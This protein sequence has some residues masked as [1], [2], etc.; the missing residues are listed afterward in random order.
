MTVS[1]LFDAFLGMRPALRRYLLLRGARDDEAE[2]VLQDVSVTLSSGKLGPVSEPGAY[3]YRMATNHFLIHRRGAG[4]RVRREEDWVDVHTGDPPEL[5]EKPST[6]TSLIA[7][8]QLAILQAVIDRMPERTRMIFRRF[9]L[10]GETRPS[11]A[12]D[13]GISISAVEKHLA[14]AYEAITAARLLL[15]EDRPLPR[16]LNAEGGNHG[17]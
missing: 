5:D 14:R 6:E 17:A 8:E 3:L 4:R 2:D 12:S 13:L 9:R 1:G 11:I 15:D 10:D 7:R 16:Y